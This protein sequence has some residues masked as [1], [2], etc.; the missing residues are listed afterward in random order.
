MDRKALVREYKESKRPMGVYRILNR[1]NGKA[2]VGS[3]P[4]VPAAL[5]RHEFEL[6]SGGHPN[7]ALQKDWNEMGADAF[8]FETLDLIEPPKDQPDYDPRDDLRTLEQ[9]WL[10][11]LLPFGDKG[12]NPEPRAK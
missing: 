1:N 9:L 6:N 12:Y 8:S 7:R 5:H 4:N 11:K 10:D 2:F 3:S